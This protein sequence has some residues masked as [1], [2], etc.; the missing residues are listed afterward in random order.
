MILRRMKPWIAWVLVVAILLCFPL[1]TAFARGG[2][3]YWG[4]QS[5]TQW[6]PIWNYWR[7]A[8][9]WGALVGAGIPHHSLDPPQFN[10]GQPP[11]QGQG[12]GQGPNSFG[13]SWRTQPVDRSVM[14]PGSSSV[15]A[16]STPGAF[17]GTVG[18][19]R[20]VPEGPFTT[21][22]Q[23][24]PPYY[25]NYNSYW[26]HGYWGGGKWG[27]SRWGGSLGTRSFPRW[28]IGPIYY[29]TGYG[30][31]ANPFLAGTKLSDA[32][33]YAEPMLRPAE[34]PQ[35]GDDVLG[36]D[37]QPVPYSADAD[38]A[39]SRAYLLKSPE[40]KAGLRAF[41]AA[42]DA[43]KKKDYQAA[44]TQIDA[45]L[46]QLPRDPAL[47]EFRALVLFANADYPSA[48]AVVYSVLSVSPG[49]NWTTLS[50]HFAEQAE[51]TRQLRDLESYRRQRP[52][53]PAPAFLSAYH[54]VTCR[55]NDAAIKQLEVVRRLLPDDR[56][57][58]PL[59][60]L[61]AGADENSQ[62]ASTDP[63]VSL[64]APGGKNPEPRI[65]KQ[66][67]TGEW[68]ATVDRNV[69]IDLTL[70]PADGFTWTVTRGKQTQK[71]EGQYTLTGSR[72]WLDA[73]GGGMTAQL[74]LGD[75]Q[76]PLRFKLA[77]NDP[78]DPGLQFHR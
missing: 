7:F 39:A 16:Q 74:S 51:F 61:L 43:F 29:G 49:W 44:Q 68:H 8:S 60:T 9:P 1:E 55:H 66:K 23:F 42:R 71:F 24:D 77:D 4:Y 70:T 38:F 52:D 20:P 75:P 31:Y 6:S 40:V 64:E 45:A 58:P 62:V 56:L 69:T 25:H 3:V 18:A 76:G 2:G 72:I 65:E 33:F 36:P 46:K 73:G 5:P 27:W 37:G 34:L 17:G 67:L 41:N 21:D 35:P 47:H 19:P 13:W 11:N 63:A 32:S 50:N 26:L 10:M 54:Y 12:Q 14:F 78:S 15:S 22:R 53:D 30:R 28:S 57:V 48:A 59:V